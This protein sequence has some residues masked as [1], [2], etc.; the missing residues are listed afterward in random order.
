MRYGLKERLLG[1]A[2]LIALAVIFLPLLFN[3]KEPEK[4]L[5]AKLH[6]PEPP[7]PLEVEVAEPVI[8]ELP[9]SFNP[10]Q[11]EIVKQHNQQATKE[12]PKL[13]AEGGAEVFAVQLASFKDENFAQRLISRQRQQGKPVYWRK[14]NGLAVVFLGP[15]L[16]RQQAEEEQ[17]RLLKEENA[18]TLI[19]SYVPEHQALKEGTLPP[20][21][22]PLVP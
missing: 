21:S 5:A 8:P 4:P 3:P 2:L 18:Q 22:Q 11:Q 9:P 14:I 10:S 16:T 6:A 1:A 15:Y 13:K 17:A 7:P 12:D 20:A 19:T